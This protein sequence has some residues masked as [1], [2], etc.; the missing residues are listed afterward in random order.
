MNR[1]V[2][3]VAVDRYDR[4]APLFTGAVAPPPGLD[5]RFLEVG[6]DPPRRHG[7]D[8]H[9]RM[10]VERE[11]DAAEVSL[12]SYLV[13]RSQG[14]E[15]LV[16]LPVFPRR[17]FS[18][19][20][21]FVSSRSDIRS[22]ADLAGRRVVIWAFQVTMSVLAKVD[23]ERDHGVDWRSVHWLTQNPE[24]IDRDYGAGV[25]IERLPGGY[26][27][28]A[29]LRAGEVDA[30]INPHP[31]E[32]VMTPGGGIERLFPDWSETTRAYFRRHG[33]FP[34]MHVLAVKAERLM[35]RPELAGELVR[36]FDEARDIARACYVDPG[37]SMIMHARN[38]L[39]YEFSHYGA[40]PWSSGIEPNRR[41]LEDF[42]GYCV[43]QR[44]LG[45][46]LAVDEIFHP[47]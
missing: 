27:V 45:G 11:F 46:P 23:L 44:L 13:A 10:L 9:R 28:V 18:Q 30:F 7:V 4:H 21:V 33:Y 20:H 2:L 34:I 22:P 14:M 6:M 32:A 15:D 8:R 40:D 42:I 41:N 1:D 25:R 24:E 47:V 36:M 35:R 38:T 5:V 17:L 16:A 39:E 26:D 31:P 43:D 19:N 12:A 3:T 29:A 37:Y